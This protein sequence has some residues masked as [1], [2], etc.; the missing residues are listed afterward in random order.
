MDGIIIIQM[1]NTAIIVVLTN[2]ALLLNFNHSVY[3]P[4]TSLRN[5]VFMCKRVYHLLLRIYAITRLL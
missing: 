1:P 4:D 5:T 2:N 3:N